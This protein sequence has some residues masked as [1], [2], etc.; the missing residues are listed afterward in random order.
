MDRRSFLSNLGYFSGSLAVACSSLGRR[1]EVLG[2]TGDVSK[3]RAAGYGE[4]FPTPAKN[5]GE[6]VLSLPRGFEY[7]VIG[8][9]GDKMADGRPTPRAHD[10]MATFKV[11]R[12]L[13]M[14]RNH[15]VSGSSIP[16]PGS[17]IGAGNHYDEMAGGGT[18]TLV[19]DPKTRLIVRDFVSLSGT[20]INCAGGPTPWGSWISCEETTLGPTVRVNERTGAKTGGFPKPHGY[21]F[22]VPASADANLPPVPLKAMGRF[23]HEAVAVDRRTGVVYL[24]EDYNPAGLY[25]FL[26]QRNKRLS[27]GGSLQVLAVKGKPQYD[28]RKGQT[29][30]TALPAEWVNI[31]NPDPESADVDPLAVFKQGR[32]RGAAS[33]ARLEGCC[34]DG[35]GRLYFTATSG[36]DSR[37]GQIWSYEPQGKDGGRLTL[38]FESPSRKLLDMPDNVCLMPNSDLLFVCEDSDYT[39]E[40]GTPEN[41]IRILTP[42]G[43]IAD[44]AVN[45]YEKSPRSE[46]AGTTFSRDGKTLFFNIQAAGITCAVWGDWSKFRA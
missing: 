21:C 24:T 19:V 8:R 40:G 23:V 29:M 14:I 45:V 32:D 31:A 22:E 37:G 10:G 5:T 7:N 46:L 12:E 18:T 16:R 2:Q 27:A 34:I 39:G 30:R 38:L 33:F 41:L 1:A 35:D 26:P 3:F 4:L 44:F 36:G 17:A 6:V 11:G 13:R 9:V 25:R 15:E 20:L 42:D 28:T 43:R